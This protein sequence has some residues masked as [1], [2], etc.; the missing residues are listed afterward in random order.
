VQ[1]LKRFIG[2]LSAPSL[3]ETALLVCLASLALVALSIQ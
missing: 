2:H 3:F 1:E